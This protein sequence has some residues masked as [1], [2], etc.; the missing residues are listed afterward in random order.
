MEDK[1]VSTVH[2]EQEMR[3]SFL[4]YAMSVI[5]ARALPD[6]RDGLKPVHRR[7]LYAMYQ[8]K[9]FFNRPH[10][11]SARI[12]GDVIGRFHPHGDSAVYEALVRMAQDFS[13][14]YPIVDGQGNFGSIDGDPPAAMR[15]TECRMQSVTELL[16]SDIDRGTVEF[17]PNY[18]SKEQEP[19][20][21]PSRLPQL[22]INGTSGIAVGMATNMP[23]H[24]LAE[25]VDGLCALIDKPDITVPEL[26]EHIKAPD[27]PTRG[28]IHGIE[29][30]R[31]AYI[32]G[33]GSI[34]LR[35]QAQ[36]EETK[37]KSRIIINEIPFQVNKARM[38][39]RVADLVRD[40]KIE[41]ISDL[42]DESAKKEI[43]IVV[44]LKKGEIPNVVLNNLYKMTPLQSSFGI[45]MVA[46]VG[47]VPQLLNLKRLLHEFYLHR[48]EVVV[49]RTAFLLRKAREKCHILEGLK[50]ATENVDAVVST[51]KNARDFATAQTQLQK[52]FKLSEMQAKSILDMRLARLTGLER[53]KIIAEYEEI[54]KKIAT[55]EGI[56]GDPRQVTKIIRDE[57]KEMKDKYGDERRTEVIRSKS[58]ELTE[59]SLVADE[60]VVL[61]I[62][63]GGYVKRTPLSQVHAQRRGGKGRSGM[64]IREEDVVRDL[65]L[66]TNHCHLLCF[67]NEGKVYNLRV[68]SMPEGNLRA[69]GKHFANMIGLKKQ[70]KIVSVLAVRE[71]SEKDYV[72][73]CTA[74]GMVKKTK[75]TAYRNVRSTGIIGLKLDI[76]DELV[77]CALIKDGDHVLIAS[78]QGKA[79]RFDQGEVRH[80]M[81]ASR[82][83]TGIRFRSKK[84]DYVIG[85]EVIRGTEGTVFSVCEN[86]FGKRTA[87]S[88][89]REQARGGQGIFTIKVTERNGPVVGLALV[90]DQDDL[91][92]ITSSGKITRF[93]VSEVGVIGRVTQGVR[94]MNIES[95][96]RVTS[97][98]RAAKVEGEEV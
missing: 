74:R 50:I 73:S 91:V 32:S 83:V 59:E 36:I 8:L 47:G 76:G 58:P 89:Y 20:V 46:L 62:T 48:Q 2:I 31:G 72:V 4:D 41:G 77:K 40:K 42:R 55:Y 1:S 49:R 69:K 28:I 87:L 57:L 80:T 3:S 43:R 16:L 98:S 79:I 51:I 18:D 35:G 15:Y 23:P 81:R 12:V 65:F 13:L 30:V 29:G 6:V 34:T 22:L 86:G 90:D 66:T 84:D 39:E 97:F 85:M 95:G 67:S 94:I 45:N 56:L 27:F 19:R 78:Q 71:F 92:I 17:V 5:V 54:L 82:G 38:I 70:E 26:M 68:F 24:N 37:N 93:N 44:E 53:D 10:L 52:K 25:V 14:R 75:L 9:N 7:I 88:E 64:L 21:L 63:I 96:E 60:K 33:R 11:K 61:T